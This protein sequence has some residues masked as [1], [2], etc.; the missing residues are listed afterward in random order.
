MVLFFPSYATEEISPPLALIAVASPL[1]EAGHEVIIVDSA[2]EPDF[3]D[4][5]LAA[6][7]GALCLGVSLI[8]G[9][10]I[11]DTLAVCR[12]AKA[13]NPDLPIILGG[14]HPSIL[15][16]QTLAADFVDAVVL[17]QG[18][19][20][21]ARVV[22]RLAAGET[23][24]G[25]PGVMTKDRSGAVVSGPPPV[26]TPVAELPSRVPG[27]ALIDYDRYE[28]QTGLRW[29]M[30]TTSHG[31]PYNCAYC[32]NAS[33]Y[34]RKLDVLPVEQVVEEVSW[35]VRRYGVSLL[36]IIDDIFFTSRERSMQIAEGFLREGLKMSWYVQDRADSVA[37]LTPAQAQMYRRSGL[38]R[39]HFGA[40]SGSDR[41]LSSIEK[42]SKVA[43]TLVAVDRC[44]EADI[45]ASF[46]FIFG[47]PDEGEE[48][49]RQ[50][51]DLIR[52]IYPALGAGRLPHQHLHPLPR[53]AAVAAQRG[54][55]GAPAGLAGGVG[56]LLP[57]PDHAALA[58]G[59]PP[60]AAPG[61]PPVP[62]LRLPQR[63]RR[64]GPGEL[65]AP[66]GAHRP[67]PLGALA[68]PQPPLR[69]PPGGPRLPR[70]PARRPRR[71][72]L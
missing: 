21:F 27:Y 61:H 15:P 68:H 69:P 31:C 42:R 20:A 38:V 44:R 16:E 72:Y 14:W 12:A 47:L 71:P 4:R 24:D 3:I 6:L 1:I 2:L 70:R 9:P 34:G 30:Y 17:K 64:R 13:R 45:R 56:G 63:P 37:K 62:P 7:D 52:E 19:V 59:R 54:D 58:P 11:A 41:V 57:A 66:A 39:V 28:R 29:V 49:M 40:E 32:S 46:G 36:G 50:T 53:L 33:V 35:L 55:G 43:R 22:E 23:L 10:M 60:Q 48:D 25:L 8:T 18:E 5:T 67:R 51:I 65:A 26:Y